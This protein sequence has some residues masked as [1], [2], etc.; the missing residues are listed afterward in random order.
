MGAS[1]FESTI[2]EMSLVEKTCCP[3]FPF[4]LHLKKA[5]FAFFHILF[6]C[7][8]AHCC[9]RA[10]GFKFFETEWGCKGAEVS[11]KMSEEIGKAQEW[12]LQNPRKR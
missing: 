11:D 9:D 7:Y 2:N 1:F 5:D 6:I 8:A 10:S 4:A 12:T 3:A